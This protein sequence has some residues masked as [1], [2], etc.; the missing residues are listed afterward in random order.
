MSL[1]VSQNSQITT[2]V[3]APSLNKLQVYSTSYRTRLGDCFCFRSSP[4]EVFLY[5]G[6]WKYAANF[7]ETTFQDGCYPVNLLLIFR[8]AFYKNTSGGL[9]LFVYQENMLLFS[10]KFFLQCKYLFSSIKNTL[11]LALCMHH[12]LSFYQGRI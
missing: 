7:T 5:K 12:W 8:A 9:L 2:C 10:E 11:T 6:F 3:R 4:S 1:K